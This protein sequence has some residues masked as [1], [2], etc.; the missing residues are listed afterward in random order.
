MAEVREE[1]GF[2][3]LWS[4]HNAGKGVFIEVQTRIT[5]PLVVIGSYWQLLGLI[6]GKNAKPW[7]VGSGTRARRAIH[8]G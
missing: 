8:G 6:A 1:M 2:A 3:N 4:I 7:R 5:T